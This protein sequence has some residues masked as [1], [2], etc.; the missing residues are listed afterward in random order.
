MAWATKLQ[1]VIGGSGALGQAVEGLC[2]A[3]VVELEQGLVMVP[4]TEALFDE[5]ADATQDSSG[6][7]FW[8]L[9]GGFGE[10]SPAGPGPG[11]SPT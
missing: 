5:V 11:P 2:A 9:P 1:A 10:C 8:F 7:G 3:R 6:S 4:M